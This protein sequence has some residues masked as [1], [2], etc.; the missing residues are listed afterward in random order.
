[1]SSTRDPSRKPAGS[2]AGAPILE[3]NGLRIGYPGAKPPLALCGEL[4][5]ALPTGLLAAVVGINGV[6]KSTLLRTL[7]GM[8]PELSGEIKIGGGPA[9]RLS[10]LR[11]ARLQSLVLTDPPA[12]RNLTVAELVALGRHPY[13]NWIGQ[14]S[15]QDRA[16][17][18]KS[19]QRMELENLRD[20]PCH[21]LSDGQLQRVQ[22]ARALAQDTPLILLDEPTTHLDLYHKVH[23]LKGLRDIAHDTQKTVLFTTHEIDLAIQLCDRILILHRDHSV[24]GDPCQLIDQGAFE[25]LFPEETVLFDRES[26]A[27]RIAK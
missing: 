17:I 22:I 2:Q 3:A 27:F 19:L 1:M 4:N 26:G 24:F 23:I 15:E 18:E 20:R 9:G 8:Q 6:G 5:F 21:T 25:T 16:C 10:A 14:Q 13:T 7:G 11:R 12:S